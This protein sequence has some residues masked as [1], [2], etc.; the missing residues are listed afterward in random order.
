MT[1]VESEQKS[2]PITCIAKMEDAE[3]RRSITA[4]K[5]RNGSVAVVTGSQF[6]REKVATTL[7]IC[8]CNLINFMDRYA[9]PGKFNHKI[10]ILNFI[11]PIKAEQSFSV[12]PIFKVYCH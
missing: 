4:S 1:A 5:M 6:T 9:L 12:L 2:P 11:S 3:E 7:I 8:F 10:F